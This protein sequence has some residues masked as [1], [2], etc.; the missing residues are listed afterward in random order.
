MAHVCTITILSPHTY[1]NSLLFLLMVSGSLS[2]YW[3]TSDL[4]EINDWTLYNNGIRY[5]EGKCVSFLVHWRPIF[6]I[7]VF[8]SK[9]KIWKKCFRKACSY[10]IKGY[11][12]SFLMF[13]RKTELTQ[14]LKK[15]FIYFENYPDA[16]LKLH[17]FFTFVFVGK[18]V[19][20]L[21]NT[22]CVTI[23]FLLAKYPKSPNTFCQR[24]YFILFSR[25]G[26]HHGYIIYFKGWIDLRTNYSL[27]E[28]VFADW[29]LAGT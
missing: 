23:Y 16:D 27:L 19:Y 2:I 18:I 24:L 15:N 14:R 6:V 11:W 3:K 7:V 10:S 8:H 12:I 1:F 26:C 29:H 21:E 25:E 17:Y 22:N 28:G 9:I 4:N 5:Q 13:Y 20:S